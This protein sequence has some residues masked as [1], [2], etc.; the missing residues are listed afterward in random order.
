[1]DFLCSFCCWQE[2]EFQ[3]AIAQIQAE[4]EAQKQLAEGAKVCGIHI[5][6]GC[7]CSLCVWCVSVECGV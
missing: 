3:A 2:G 1:M 6:V 7:V 4:L 5:P